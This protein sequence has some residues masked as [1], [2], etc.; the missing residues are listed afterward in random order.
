M[1]LAR[2]QLLIEEGRAEGIAEG[3]EKQK[4]NT[5][6]FIKEMQKKACLPKKFWHH[7]RVTN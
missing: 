5:V 6:F 3:V 7:F 1:L 2:E 4:Q